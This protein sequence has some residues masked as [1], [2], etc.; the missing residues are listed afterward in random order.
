MTAG[1]SRKVALGSDPSNCLK[2]LILSFKKALFFALESI[3][4]A[5][6]EKNLT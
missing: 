4:S 6:I 5:Q 1:L 2:S 3:F